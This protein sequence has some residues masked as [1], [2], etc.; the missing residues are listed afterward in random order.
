MRIFT[1]QAL[2][3]CAESHPNSKAALQEWASVVKKSKWTCFAD[4]KQAFNSVGNVGNQ[5]YV[6][7]IKGNN[8]RLVVVIKFTVR[9]VYIR[10]IGTH[11]EYDKIDCANI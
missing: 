1:E 2:K 10:F 5:H 4:V 3:E 9:F 6:F 7:N 11:A 8:Y